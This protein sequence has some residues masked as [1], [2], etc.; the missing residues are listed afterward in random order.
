MVGHRIKKMK[1]IIIASVLG[2]VAGVVVAGYVG[3]KNG[4]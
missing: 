2:I 3:G 1:T 4:V